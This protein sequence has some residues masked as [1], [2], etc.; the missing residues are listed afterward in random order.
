MTWMSRSRVYKAEVSLMHPFSTTWPSL[1]GIKLCCCR[2]LLSQKFLGE[3]I[4]HLI[5]TRIRTLKPLCCHKIHQ[6]QPSVY[7][8]SGMASTLPDETCTLIGAFSP[9]PGSGQV[10]FLL[11][12]CLV[13]GPCLP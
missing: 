10:D 11:A 6:P 3:G 7:V 8:F 2:T 9:V 1:A 13:L 5:N 12:W 4:G